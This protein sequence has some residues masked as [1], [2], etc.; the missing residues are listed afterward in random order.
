[1]Q[2]LTTAVFLTVA[3]L[4]NAPALLEANQHT[5]IPTSSPPAL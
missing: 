3:V 1:M 5:A 2:R 4:V